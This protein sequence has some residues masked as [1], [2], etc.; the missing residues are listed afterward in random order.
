MKYSTIILLFHILS[1][2][3]PYS[4]QSQTAIIRVDDFLYEKGIQLVEEIIVSNVPKEYSLISDILLKGIQDVLP[5]DIRF[6]IIS[7][8]RTKY[9]EDSINGFPRDKEV[10]K[11]SLFLQIKEIESK[12][13]PGYGLFG[14]DPYLFQK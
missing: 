7:S 1:L 13:M 8:G 3:Q 9:E 11:D 4:L 5:K 2:V 10:K 6:V 14:L 12:A